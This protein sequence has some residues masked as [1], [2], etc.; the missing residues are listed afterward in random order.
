MGVKEM[1]LAKAKK[2]REQ[3]AGKNQP[4]T[5]T[6]KKTAPKA[7]ST[8]KKSS[9]RNTDIPYA[10][11]ASMYDAGK[12]VSEI[13]DHFGWTDKKSNWPYSYTYGI[14]KRLRAGVQ[15]DGKTIKVQP[16]TKK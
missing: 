7:D 9:V 8:K 3:Q 14:L 10:K 5:T 16:K 15:I 2:L 11:V 13:S 1:A 4:T 6:T 12:S